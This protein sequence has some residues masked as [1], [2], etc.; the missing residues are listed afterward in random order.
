MH[1]GKAMMTVSFPVRQELQNALQDAGAVWSRTHRSWLLPCEEESVGLIKRIFGAATYDATGLKNFLLARRKQQEKE[2]AGRPRG[3]NEAVLR[4]FCRMMELKGYSV[5]TQR[6]YKNAFAHIL[7]LLG[8]KYAAELDEEHWLLLLHWLQEKRGF[9]EAQMHTAVNVIRFYNE[10]VMRREALPVYLPRVKKAKQL[11]N[12]ISEEETEKILNVV[13]NIKHLCM[14]MLAYG[15]GMR[16]SEITN[17]QLKDIDSKRSLIAIRCAKGK[18]DRVVPLPA[19]LLPILRDYYRLYKPQLYLFENE[20][21]ERYSTRSVQ[22]VFQRA[23]QKAGIRKSGGIHSFRHSYATHLL[24]AGTD[25]RVIQELLGHSQLKTTMIY[26]H[27]SNLLLQ[28]VKSPLDNLTLQP[29][30][31]PVEVFLKTRKRT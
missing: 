25:I 6:T 27:V 26:T 18:K 29:S 23:K 2:E 31:K 19:Q 1:K 5:N 11:P 14:L 4:D 28:H 16:V 21:G 17:L 12:V 7:C 8:E 9:K 15:C 20:P 13:T 10:K 3:R 24:E 30:G 22:T